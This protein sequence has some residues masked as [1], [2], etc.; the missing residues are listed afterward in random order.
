MIELLEIFTVQQWFHS[1]LEWISV[2]DMGEVGAG[3]GT[4]LGGGE[5]VAYRLTA[6]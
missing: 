5:G 4:A 2:Q 3:A 1:R 6:R